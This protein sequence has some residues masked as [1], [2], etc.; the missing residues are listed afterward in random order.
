MLLLGSVKTGKTTFVCSG[1]K[2]APDTVATAG[3]IDA[4]DVLLI[5]RDAEG[6]LGPS[7]LGYNPLVADLSGVEGWPQLN[8]ELAKV[9]MEASAMAK[10]GQLSV[11]GIDLGTIAAEIVNWAAGDVTIPKGKLTNDQ[12]STA[13]S[14]VDWNKVSATGLMF[15]R[16][17]RTLP[18]L[19]VAQCH[20]KLTQNNPMASKEGSDVQLGRAINSVGGETSKVSADVVKGVLAPWLANSS[21]IFARDVDTTIDPKTK[22]RVQTYRTI[23]A[24]DGMYSVG[25]RRQS[26]L[27]NNTDLSLRRLMEI[28]YKI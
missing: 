14:Q 17:M 2:Q 4:S 12:I 24:P 5:Q 1:S 27:P 21:Y 11:I 10:A 16:A 15:Y 25:N 22:G 19:V 3:R 20:V 7:D 9:V 18:C 26:V 23:T 28:A 13:G 8:T 6:H